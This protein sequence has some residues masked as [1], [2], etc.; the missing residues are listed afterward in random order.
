MIEF[1]PW[2][3]SQTQRNLL[4]RGEVRNEET[5]QTEEIRT[6]CARTDELSRRSE[7]VLSS[8]IR[9]VTGPIAI[10]VKLRPG[11]RARGRRANREEVQFDAE[12]GFGL[13]YAV[14]GTSAI[15]NWLSYGFVG[16]F[17]MSSVPVRG[18]DGE[19]RKMGA[20]SLAVGGTLSYLT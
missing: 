8:R 17:G 5:D 9:F 12:A 14:G 6:W 10:P 7:Q 19:V 18:V 20:F 13:A 2:R 3:T 4:W 16:A 11:Y 15:N 1:I